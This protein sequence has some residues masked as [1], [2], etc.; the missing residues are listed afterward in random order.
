MEEEMTRRK[1]VKD[2]T[3]N[4][5][6]ENVPPF[7]KGDNKELF[8]SILRPRFDFVPTVCN[9]GINCQHLSRPQSTGMLQ[10]RTARRNLNSAAQQNRY[11]SIVDQMDLHLGLKLPS[12]N[13]DSLFL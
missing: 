2:K 3:R 6:S 5:R 9:D 4:G 7:L 13:W 10:D 11:G 1:K 12:R 8:L